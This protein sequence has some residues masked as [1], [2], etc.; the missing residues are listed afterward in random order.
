MSTSVLG[1]GNYLYRACFKAPSRKEDSRFSRLVLKDV[2]ACENVTTE[3]QR[4]GPEIRGTL[5]AWK[6][7]QIISFKIF[8]LTLF[9]ELD[10]ARFR[11]SNVTL[12]CV[13]YLDLKGHISKDNIHKTGVQM[14]TIKI[15]KQ[16]DGW[17]ST[18]IIFTNGLR[19]FLDHVP[20]NQLITTLFV[21]LA[22]DSY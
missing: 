2:K 10:H 5:P 3:K 12:T 15:H 14:K 6:S 13:F 1:Q 11:N 7:F 16:S 9:S 20:I 21:S 19:H 17:T 18:N 22:P 8:T 4:E